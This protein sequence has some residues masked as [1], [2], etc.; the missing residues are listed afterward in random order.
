MKTQKLGV[1][2]SVDLAAVAA[3]GDEREAV[4]TTTE[5]AIKPEEVKPEEVKP[6]GLEKKKRAKS[7]T[8]KMADKISDVPKPG[9]PPFKLSDYL[10]L[11][12][13]RF[14]ANVFLYAESNSPLAT[15]SEALRGWI[16]ELVV[17]CFMINEY[18]WEAFSNFCLIHGCSA[19]KDSTFRCPTLPWRKFHMGHLSDVLECSMID[20]LGMQRIFRM[21]GIIL[22]LRI[23]FNI[24]FMYPLSGLCP[25]SDINIVVRKWRS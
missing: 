10:V 17:R 5:V 1:S 11:L 18:G 3:A 15:K 20:F 9:L 13:K 19:A 24:A 22:S 4:V 8:R 6:E 21:I 25:V 23:I 12:M 16:A 2:P 7:F 14:C